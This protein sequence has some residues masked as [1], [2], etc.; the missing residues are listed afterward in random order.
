MCPLQYKFYRRFGRRL[1]VKNPVRLLRPEDFPCGD[2]PAET[3][4]VAQ[5]LSFRQISLAPLKFPREVFLFGDIHARAG[6]TCEHSVFKDGR[7]DTTYPPHPALR[8]YDPIFRVA[9]FAFRYHSLDLAFHEF[10]IVGVHN[11]QI[12]RDRGYALSRVNTENVKPLRRPVFSASIG[13]EGP[14]PD[15]RKPLRF[16]EI[17]LAQP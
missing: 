8:V 14:T 16:G 12:L 15:M 7:A 10:A 2:N 17:G 4:G 11:L 6:E 3:T 1:V 5:A 9:A 13:R